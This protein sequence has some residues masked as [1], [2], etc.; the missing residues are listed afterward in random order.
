[1]FAGGFDSTKNEYE[2]N[3][4]IQSKLAIISFSL[5]VSQASRRGSNISLGLS[6]PWPDLTISSARCTLSRSGAD[7]LASRDAAIVS[8]AE[9]MRTAET[10]C[11]RDSVRDFLGASVES[12]LECVLTDA[13]PLV[14]RPFGRVRLGVA[15]SSWGCASPLLLEASKP[16]P[17]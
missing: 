13:V 14:L 10:V 15:G 2:I 1:M 12:A 17:S 16:L 8:N 7:R 5:R 9:E 4:E 11:P 6:P 3:L